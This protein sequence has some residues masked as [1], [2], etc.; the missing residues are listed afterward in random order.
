MTPQ[1][2]KEFDTLPVS[3]HLHHFPL[4]SLQPLC[5][6]KQDTGAEPSHLRV[7][8]HHQFPRG[9]WAVHGARRGGTGRI[10]TT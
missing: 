5:K 2:G 4:T 1:K 9:G 7:A 8:A 10:F 6:R 3:C